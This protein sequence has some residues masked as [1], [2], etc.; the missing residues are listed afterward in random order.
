MATASAPYWHNLYRK[1][2]MAKGGSPSPEERLPM[3]MLG[4]FLTV[5]GLFIFAFTSYS[6][7]SP[8][9]PIVG[10]IPFG[11]GTILI[12]SGVFT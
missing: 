4:S 1:R 10:S 12:Y 11:T 2:V 7:V 6:N 5:I 8:A 3:C 9:G